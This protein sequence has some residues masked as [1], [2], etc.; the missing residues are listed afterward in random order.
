MSLDAR[1]VN[2]PHATAL[3]ALHGRIL[4]RYLG[5]RRVDAMTSR[6]T[7]AMMEYRAP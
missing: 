1:S 7:S 4:S 2:H 3:M 5:I 6:T